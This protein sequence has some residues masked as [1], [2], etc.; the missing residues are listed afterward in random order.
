M[1]NIEA[2]VNS[3]VFGGNNDKDLIT[4]NSPD[5]TPLML[6][7]NKEGDHAKVN[8]QTTTIC[9]KEQEGTYARQAHPLRILMMMEKVR[10]RLLKRKEKERWELERVHVLKGH[11]TKRSPL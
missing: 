11:K 3:I 10:S 8:E 1:E 7:G 2:L 4:K 6:H 5:L 9:H